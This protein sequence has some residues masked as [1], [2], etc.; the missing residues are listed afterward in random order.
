MPTS[1]EIEARV[2]LGIKHLERCWQ[3]D[4]LLERLR[5]F[6]TNR[7]EAFLLDLREHHKAAS[8]EWLERVNE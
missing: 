8:L 1:M 4:E 5:P 6:I 7:E 3:I 2:Q